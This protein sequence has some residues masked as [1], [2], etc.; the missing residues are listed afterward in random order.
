MNKSEIVGEVAARTGLNRKEAAGAVN[1]MFEAVTDALVRRQ[2]VRIAGF[3]Q[4]A[5]RS[6]PARTSR[7]PRTGEPVAV[8]ASTAPTFK[9]ARAL[10]EAVNAG[11]TS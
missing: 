11:V 10:R 2:E 1:A 4:F 6:R 3:G 9:T 5:T 7:N 8:A